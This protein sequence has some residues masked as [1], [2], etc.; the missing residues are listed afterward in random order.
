MVCEQL[1]QQKLFQWL[2]PT[3]ILVQ[4]AFPLTSI[5]QVLIHLSINPTSN[6]IYYEEGIVP[7]TVTYTEKYHNGYFN[8]VADTKREK[9]Y[10]SEL[11]YL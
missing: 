10:F 6:G 5:Q 3:V 9:Q 1:R 8:T 4:Y 2:L 11:N 7:R